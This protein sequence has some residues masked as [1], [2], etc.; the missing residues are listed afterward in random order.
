MDEHTKKTTVYLPERVH[1]QLNALAKAHKR[2]FNSELV[3]VVEQYI[4]K[5]QRREKKL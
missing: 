2:S 1:A 4:Q 5:E 3:W